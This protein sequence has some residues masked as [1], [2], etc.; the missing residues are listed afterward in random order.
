MPPHRETQQIEGIVIAPPLDYGQLAWALP[1]GLSIDIT[2]PLLTRY[3]R[4]YVAALIDWYAPEFVYV[5][6]THGSLIHRQAIAAGLTDCA[7]PH[8]S[9]WLLEPLSAFTWSRG[10]AHAGGSVVLAKALPA[11]HLAAARRLDETALAVVEIEAMIAV[12][13]GEEDVGPAIVVDVG[14]SDAQSRQCRG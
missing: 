12:A 11:K 8:A 3:V 1:I 6:W 13:L 10:D 9:R 5:T 4:R 14:D 7:V 2:A